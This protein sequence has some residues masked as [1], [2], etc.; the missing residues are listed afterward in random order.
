[1]KSE[2]AREL[3]ETWQGQS[4]LRRPPPE[5]VGRW[6]NETWSNITW[7][8]IT[9]SNITWSNITWSNITS[10]WDNT[11]ERS[12][13]FSNVLHEEKVAV[14]QRIAETK[15][16]LREHVRTHGLVSLSLN[17]QVG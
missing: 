3:F 12:P 13:R 10:P 2:T 14:D 7:S 5:R 6:P 15:N 9:W 16:K 1:M 17:Q 4:M 8:N 11:T